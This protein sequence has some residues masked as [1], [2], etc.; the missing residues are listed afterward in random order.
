MTDRRDDYLT[1]DEAARLWQRAASLQGEAALREEAVAQ[2]LAE[3]EMTSVVRRDGYAVEHVRTAA[4]EAGI[5]GQYLDAALADLRAE[6]ALATEKVGSAYARRFLN[7]PPNALTVRREIRAPVEK[8]LAAMEEIFPREPYH[9]SLTDRQSDSAH[10]ELLSFIIEGA[11]FVAPEGF[12]GQMSAGNLRRVVVSIRPLDG[13]D[14]GSCE[15]TIRGPIAWAHNL[16]AGVGSVFTGIIGAI[17]LGV[18]GAGGAAIATTLVA[19]SIATI[20]V[21][22]VAAAAVTVTGVLGGST[23]AA[24]GFRALH[25]YSL[26]K[27]Q[28]GLNDLLSVV[29][30]HAQGGWGLTGS[31]GLSAGDRTSGD[32]TSEDRTSED[33]GTTGKFAPP[34]S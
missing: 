16:N 7:D 25:T 15:M 1:E 22:A 6:S 34:G 31:R 12:K 18:G 30:S 33:G 17:G 24:H 26:N 32:R 14:S 10:G 27:G 8:V 4:I 13:P 3:D 9:M 2:D 29:A 23:L 19:S 5:G 20:G 11:S 21:A 28:Q